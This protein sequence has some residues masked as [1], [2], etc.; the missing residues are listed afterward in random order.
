V[1][2]AFD[3]ETF[4][5]RPGVQAP[6]LVCLTWARPGFVPGIVHARMDELAAKE[7]VAAWLKYNEILVGHH[8]PYDL[9][10][11]AAKWPEFLGDIFDKLD[12][13]EIED[14]K[15]RQ[16]LLDIAAG[17]FR[18]YARKFEKEVVDE[19]TGTVKLVRGEVWVPHKYDL[20]DVYYRA[21]GI[22]LEKDEWRRTYSQFA[23]VPLSQWP[24]GARRYAMD[25]ASA[26]LEIRRQQE[27]HVKWIPD[28]HDQVRAAWAL[29]LCQTWGLRTDLA[30]VDE[31]EV[32][33]NVELEKIEEGLKKEGLVRRGKAFGGEGKEGTRDLKKA[34]ARMLRACGWV[35]NPD[36]KGKEKYVPV[37]PK[38]KPLRLTEKGN[39]SLDEDACK[40]SEDLLLED[41]AEFTSLKNVLGKDIK[42]LRGGT[43]YPV[44]TSYGMAASGRTTSSKPNVQNPRRLPGIREC[45]APRA[46]YLFAQA[47]YSSL[48]LCTLAQVCWSRFGESKMRELINAGFDL[49]TQF[50]SRLLRL[51]YEETVALV[52]AKD[53]RAKTARQTSKVA[54]FGYPGGL[55]AESFIVYAKGYD[56][57]LNFTVEEAKDLKEEWL[58]EWPEIRKF[59]ENIGKLVGDEDSGFITQLFSNRFRGGMKY[60]AACNTE[61]QGLGADAAKRGLYYVQRACYSPR[62]GMS[63]G[64]PPV[65]DKS[66]SILYGCRVVLFVHDE[67]VMEVL[68]DE[69]AHDKA[70]EMS[71]LMCA[72]AKEFIPDVK[73]AADPILAR[74]WSKE[75]EAVTNEEGRLIPWEPKKSA[76]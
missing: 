44:H 66:K 25:D 9:G 28:Q 29:W 40:A 38:P 39:I 20:A 3:S 36:P 48:E 43:T 59:F 47:D 17:E 10:V 70:H 67:I 57:D 1:I 76:A 12:R 56:E 16:Q 4:R 26:T 2:T 55:G 58:L 53:K 34:K 50:A 32:R 68:D 69:H 62:G 15:L 63:L 24:E 71:R 54:N 73:V 30:S 45:W 64:S 19:E 35:E 23:D 60:C 8:V 5:F 46:G 52:K 13:N 61:F 14:T 49:H 27:E 31:L 72:G 51:S 41:Y 11:I 42:I 75:M 18:G 74:R 37:V 21:T 7:L 6:E 65:A 22:R 33:T